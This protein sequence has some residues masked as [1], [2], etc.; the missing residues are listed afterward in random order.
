MTARW[1]QLSRCLTQGKSIPLAQNQGA[2]SLFSF[3]RLQ[4][5]GIK[6]TH[7][8]G[9]KPVNITATSPPHGAEV[10][11]PTPL[12]QKTHKGMDGEG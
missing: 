10:G 8:A 9:G 4:K 6:N 3:S 11:L 7:S 5:D 1:S 12:I 2:E